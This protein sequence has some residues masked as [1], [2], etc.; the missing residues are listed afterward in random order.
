MTKFLRTKL[1]IFALSLLLSF[2]FWLNVSG[3]DT[4]V[5]DIE[6]ALVPVNEPK[7]RLAL[8]DIPETV[9]V[10]ITANTAQFR[11][12]ENRRHVVRLDVSEAVAGSNTI[13]LDGDKIVPPLPRGASAKLVPEAISFEAYGYAT[14]ELPVRVPYQGL[15]R[16]YLQASGQTVLEVT[17]ATALVSGPTNRL[18]NLM[19]LTTKAVDL[20]SFANPETT[21]TIPP[22]LTGPA[23][24]LTV[25]PTEFKVRALATVKRKPAVFRVPVRLKGARPDIPATLS[26]EAVT[27]SVSWPLNV[28]DPPEGSDGG[29]KAVADVDLG[30]L[31]R[32]RNVRVVIEVETPVGVELLSVRPA[33]VTANWRQPP[34][35]ATQPPTQPAPPQTP[36][37]E[38]EPQ[39]TPTAE[40]KP[41]P[42]AG[43][44]PPE[45]S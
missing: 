11:L 13:P 25:S 26:P 8:D 33:S 40:P 3:Q 16:E 39:R 24:E 19:E 23:R 14:V 32:R 44:E 10:R 28:P 21:L 12:I 38:S 17:P 30:T 36:P 43:A 6:A 34:E 1:P 15:L 29:L 20:R 2:C 45:A 22:Q 27:V 7:V 31:E 5:H 4:S 42:P 35:S 9:T 18:E 41:A 37:S